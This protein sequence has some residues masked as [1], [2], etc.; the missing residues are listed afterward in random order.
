MGGLCFNFFSDKALDVRRRRSHLKV[1]LTFDWSHR[2]EK[3]IWATPLIGRGTPPTHLLIGLRV[4]LSM[5]LKDEG[6]EQC[7]ARHGAMASAVW[8]AVDAW[9]KGGPVHCHIHDA[10]QRSCTMTTIRIDGFKCKELLD[11]CLKEGNLLLAPQVPLPGIP[12]TM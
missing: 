8:A 2:L 3:W 7:W 4:A 9:S 12:A 10:S 1:P 5:L 6:L 11:W